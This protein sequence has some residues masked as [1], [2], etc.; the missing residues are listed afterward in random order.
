MARDLGLIYCIWCAQ[1][2]ISGW[3]YA[4]IQGTALVSLWYLAHECGHGAFSSFP[5]V[6]DIVGFILHTGLLVPYFAWKR[7]H[8]MHHA[9][10]NHLL[11]G[12]SSNPSMKSKTTLKRMSD[13]L[14]ED[15]FVAVRACCLAGLYTCSCIDR[16]VAVAP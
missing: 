5:I 6:N 8:A 15:A 16:A 11:D 1:P 3:V 4:L 10:S 9:K 2:Y 14:C 13:L 7:T 12:E